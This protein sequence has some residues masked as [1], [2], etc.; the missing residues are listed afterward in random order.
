MLEGPQGLEFA[1]RFCSSLK[2]FT[3]LFDTANRQQ[4]VHE[5]VLKEVNFVNSDENCVA[6]KI[7]CDICL[8]SSV[9][10]DV[11]KLF[12]D[13]SDAEYAWL[14]FILI[15]IGSNSAMAC[16]PQ[17]KKQLIVFTDTEVLPSLLSNLN[18]KL[19]VKIIELYVEKIGADTS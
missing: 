13:K 3:Q 10:F 12:T 8:E 18:D 7:F 9:A 15:N 16:L 14:A 1:S 17:L 2:R 4:V 5:I 11:T 6:L 19:L